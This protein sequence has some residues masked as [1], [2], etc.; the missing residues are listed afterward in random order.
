MNWARVAWAMSK[1]GKSLDDAI[2]EETARATPAIRIA[3]A[4][5]R[6]ADS[7]GELARC[8][9]PE[10]EVDVRIC[11]SVETCQERD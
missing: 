3:V 2:A 7:L 8:V 11:G 1:Q 9:N 10:N 5:E 4:L 6:I